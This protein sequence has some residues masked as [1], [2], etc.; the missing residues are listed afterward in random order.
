MGLG[1]RLVRVLEPTAL[2]SI[3]PRRWQSWI[4]EADVL[5]SARRWAT[6]IDGPAYAID[7]Q[8]AI[9]V[10]DGEARIVSEGNLE[11]FN[12]DGAGQRAIRNGQAGLTR[13][14]SSVASDATRR[15]GLP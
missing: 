5:P 7:D 6:K 12:L 4:R 13:S 11:S 2:P 15:A 14:G 8:S 1:W 9:A 10:V 3:S